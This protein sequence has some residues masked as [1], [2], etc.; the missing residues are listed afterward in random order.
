MP[1][2]LH[3]LGLKPKFRL[4]TASKPTFPLEKFTSNRQI[5][6]HIELLILQYYRMK[7]MNPRYFRGAASLDRRL[8]TGHFV[9]LLAG[10]LFGAL[11]FIGT[12][13]DAANLFSIQERLKRA[14]DAAALNGAELLFRTPSDSADSA[15]L[16]AES[17]ARDNLLNWSISLPDSEVQMAVEM[18][19]AIVRAQIRSDIPLLMLANLPGFPAHITLRANS[20]AQARS[21][22]M[23]LVLDLSTSMRFPASSNP[24]ETES[25]L[26]KLK[27]AANV[28]IDRLDESRDRLGIVGFGDDDPS[29]TPNPTRVLLEITEAPFNRAAAHAVIDAINDNPGTSYLSGKTNIAKGLQLATS[30][31][32]SVSATDRH[33]LLISDGTPTQSLPASLP[34]C[35]PP[36]GTHDFLSA[37]LEAKYA[38]NSGITNSIVAIGQPS[39]LHPC[40][41]PQYSC[42]DASDPRNDILGR[43]L[44][45]IASS[46][47]PQYHC[48]LSPDPTQAGSA[49]MFLASPD[50]TRLS[51]MFVSIVDFVRNRLIE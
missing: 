6:R 17:I 30:Q 3:Q 42:F 36:S 12:I 33:T 1:R 23:V 22:S 26:D 5:C 27:Q 32:N 2:A 40:S 15:I 39:S 41:W 19:S 34:S 50:A 4:S 46:A 10:S 38:R 25:K 37:L 13:I 44:A 35:T 24:G 28:L 11:L 14:A 49:G 31:L 29:K 16:R 18:P 51:E 8:E 9:I 20:A 7:C 47:D 43:A 21:L 48:G 45:G